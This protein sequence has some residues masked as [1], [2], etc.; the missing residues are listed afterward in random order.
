MSKIL[1]G[2]LTVCG[3]NVKL[4]WMR[5]THTG[6]SMLARLFSKSA[7]FR[8]SDNIYY[9]ITIPKPLCRFWQILEFFS[10]LPVL[11]TKFFLPSMMG[12]TVVAE[13]YLLDFIVWVSI[14]TN[15]SKYLCCLETR[16]LID[17]VLKTKVKVY[18]TADFD[19]LSNRRADS[20]VFLKKQL[21]IYEDL[22]KSVGAFRLDTSNKTEHESASILLALLE[23]TFSIPAPD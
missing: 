14:V 9:G 23:K 1:V 4:S 3:F 22:A 21:N 5:G 7:V 8:G 19:V 6:A 10:L 16:F 20:A 17:L 12:K 13:R 18:V 2:T 11:L 15:D